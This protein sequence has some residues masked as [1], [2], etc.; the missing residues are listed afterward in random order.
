[1]TMTSGPA[2]GCSEPARRIPL[3]RECQVWLDFDGTVTRR[4]LLDDLIQRYA[5]NDSWKELERRWA[6]G[7]I[8]SRAC[9]EGEFSLLEITAEKLASELSR[10]EL[11]PGAA[12]LLTLLT[13]RGVDV[14]ILSDGMEPFIRHILTENGIVPPRIRANQ[15]EHSRTS[16]RPTF[17]YGSSACVSGAGHCK[18]ESARTLGAPLK[19]SIYIGDGRSDLCPARS[20]DLVFAKG[21]LARALSAELKPF[22]PFDTLSDVQSVLAKAW[23]A[24]D[25]RHPEGEA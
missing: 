3:A 23:G 25:S 5:I 11:D 8:G 19:R 1:M 6:A 17:P 2:Q 22:R 20:C 10:V 4:D 9:L 15:V 21:A 14:T 12:D 7:E 13:G 16:L 24:A 18:C